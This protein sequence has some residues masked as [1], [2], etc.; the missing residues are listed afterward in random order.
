MVVNGASFA[1]QCIAWICHTFERHRKLNV[2]SHSWLSGL[3]RRLVWRESGLNILL[4]R[5]QSSHAMQQ[6]GC[7]HWT[8]TWWIWSSLGSW[9]PHLETVL[10]YNI[11]LPTGSWLLSHDC[12]DVGHSFNLLHGH[13]HQMNFAVQ[14]RT[15][16]A[17]VEHFVIVCVCFLFSCENLVGTRRQ[18]KVNA[19]MPHRFSKIP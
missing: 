2:W 4:F 6:K 7:R 5:I 19:M 12:W 14:K 10:V 13:K 17:R 9:Q 15:L 11:P 8:A 1:A 18:T 3:L 16:N